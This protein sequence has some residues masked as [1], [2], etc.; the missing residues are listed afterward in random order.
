MKNCYFAANFNT[1][2]IPFVFLNCRSICNKTSDLEYLIDSYNSLPVL[3][4]TESWLTAADPDTILPYHACYNIF[5]HDRLLRRGGGVVIMTPK[6]IPAYM[7][8]SSGS[9]DD[10]ESIWVN[11]DFPNKC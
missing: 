11:L 6:A 9:S 4:L 8:T 3:L 5:R 1:N 2:F 7:I 10:F